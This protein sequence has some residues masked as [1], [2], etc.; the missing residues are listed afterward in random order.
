MLPGPLSVSFVIDV[1]FLT[2]GYVVIVVISKFLLFNIVANVA[3]E[4][5]VPNLELRLDRVVSAVDRGRSL[6]PTYQ[7]PVFDMQP[8]TLR[9]GRVIQY[10]IPA[11]SGWRD[12]RQSGKTT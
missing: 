1:Q 6:V 2:W 4:D 3:N 12:W 9:S 10:L 5:V 8:S 7:N 11:L